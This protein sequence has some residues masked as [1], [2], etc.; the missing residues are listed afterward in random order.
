MDASNISI[1]INN[2]IKNNNSIDIS[3]IHDSFSTQANN[4]ELL[5][6]E[7]KVAFLHIYKNQNFINDFHDFLLDHIIKLGFLVDKTKSF[8]LLS[9]NKTI[10]IPEKPI[11]KANYDLEDCVLNS[12]YLVG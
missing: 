10:I 3:T 5:S 1:L 6:Y 12:Q 8:V 4:I 7:V 9:P 2:I 11:F